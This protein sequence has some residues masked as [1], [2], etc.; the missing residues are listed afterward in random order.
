M[1]AHAPAGAFATELEQGSDFRF[2]VHQASGMVSGQLE[3][4]VAEA[5]IRL[6]ASA[7]AQ[8]RSVTDLAEDV[9]ARRLHYE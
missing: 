5:L 3:V 9:V 2:V 1:Q 6:R 8:N 7:F 4:S